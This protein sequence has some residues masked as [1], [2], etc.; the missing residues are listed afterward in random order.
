MWRTSLRG[1]WR[2]WKAVGVAMVLTGLSVEAAEMPTAGTR[3][4]SPKTASAAPLSLL[5]ALGSGIGTSSAPSAKKQAPS[6]FPQT[7]ATSI[8]PPAAA[9]EA[10]VSDQPSAPTA[11]PLT[12]PTSA[13]LPAPANAVEPAVASGSFLGKPITPASHTDAGPAPESAQPKPEA[14][15]KPQPEAKPEPPVADI[16]VQPSDAKTDSD[17]KPVDAKPADA[18]LEP[19]PDPQQSG[20]VEI[21]AASFNHVTPGVS[22]LADVQKAWGAPKEIANRDSVVLQLYSVGPFE[23]VEVSFFQDKV[24]SIVIRLNQSFP[25]NAVAE[26]LQLSAIRPVFVSNALGE[27]LGQAFPERGVLF[28]FE[29]G[30]APGKPSMKV[31]QI[32]LEPIT[33]E[34]FV[35]RAETVLDSQLDQ[36]SKDLE[37]AIKLDST[38]ARAHWLRARVRFAL[39]D[40]NQALASATESVQLEPS[41]PQYRLM[42]A[43]ILGQAGQF[44]AAVQEAQQAVDTAE[45]RPH[46]KAQAVCLLGDLA[47]SGPQPDY[48]KAMAY[49]VDAL[50][51]AEPLA[52]SPHPAIRVAAKEVLVSAHLGAAHDIAWGNWN[53]KEVAVPRWLDRAAIIAEDLVD[54]E[55]AS[56]EQRFRV[57]VRALAA[58]VG[59]QGKLD[60]AVWADQALKFADD[61]VAATPVAAQKQRVQWDLGMALYDAVQVCQMRGDHDTAL[62]YGQQ[63]I[64][65]LEKGSAE[66]GSNIADV[67]LLARLYF[68]M[69]A[70]FAVGKQ[71]HKTAVTWFDKANPMFTRLVS[72]IGPAEYGRLGETF[73]SM[74]ISY[75]E[76]GS[77]EKAMEMTQQGV[78]LIEQLVQKGAI[79]PS[80]LDI[81]YSNLATMHRQLGQNSQ[82]EALLEKA[83]KLKR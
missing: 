77:R 13:A 8:A 74:G 26:Q 15:A 75:W 3:T 18:P 6:L 61:L 38:N 32:I 12:P 60:P 71:D 39:E 63:A 40:L 44:A 41:N 51:A 47:S 66:D 79:E 33:A 42:R 1:L 56:V 76:T 9:A 72:Q 59:V 20:V 70:L 19:I 64:E 16:Q 67:Y 17:A 69:G 82:A 46:I 49:H 81:P 58:A 35:L 55:G 36:S 53:Q 80:A 14:E 11:A 37:A 50:K 48:K 23:K 2:A 68:R 27:I 28:A 21:E 34:P 31:S 25:A 30:E 57:A 78:D 29:P 54:K 45:R 7:N 10:I 24:T 52:Q 62:K 22:T 83:G 43:Q 4:D 5:E 65:H 73:V